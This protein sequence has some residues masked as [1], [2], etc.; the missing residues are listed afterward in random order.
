MQQGD[1]RRERIVRVEVDLMAG[2]IGQAESGDRRAAA[3][4]IL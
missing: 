2:K 3:K 1:I 4:N